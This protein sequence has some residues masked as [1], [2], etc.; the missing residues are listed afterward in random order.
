MKSLQAYALCLCGCCSVM[1]ALQYMQELDMPANMQSVISKLPFKL[2]DQWRITAY[3]IMETC[4]CQ[5]CFIDLVTFIERHVRILSDPLFGD[6]QESSFGVTGTKTLIRFKSQPKERMKGN[7]FATTVANIDSL[8]G[9]GSSKSDLG[10]ADKKYCLCCSNNH[11]LKE[12]D[13]F[14]LKKHTEKIGFLRKKGVCFACLCTGHMSKYCKGRLKCKVC[15][16]AHPTVLHIE[17]QSA[18]VNQSSS[19]KLGFSQTCGH[20]GVGRD[21]CALSILPVQVKSIKGN[22]VIKTYAFLDPGSSATFCSEQLM[23]KLNISG[24]PVTFLLSTMGQQAIV[25]AY[26]LTGLEVSSLDGNNF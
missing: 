7:N 25:P 15:H 9:V 5:A 16:Q 4:N 17:R 20:T 18:A 21:R 1:E 3:D 14:N 6:I 13:R 24:K 2:R 11:S 8:S 10:K 23:Q 26:S 22:K 19:N 12:C